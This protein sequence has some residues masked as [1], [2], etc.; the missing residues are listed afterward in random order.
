MGGG[1]D[2]SAF[3]NR[4]LEILVSFHSVFGGLEVMT[5]VVS[6][7]SESGCWKQSQ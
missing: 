3:S 6:L 2:L 1:V 7:A 5:L 4:Y